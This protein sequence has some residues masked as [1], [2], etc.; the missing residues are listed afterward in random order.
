[1]TQEQIEVL[2]KLRQA[3][4]AGV[5]PTAPAPGGQRPKPST[6]CPVAAMDPCAQAIKDIPGIDPALCRATAETAQSACLA[7]RSDALTPLTVAHCQAGCAAFA[8]EAALGLMIYEAAMA[9]VERANAPP[10]DPARD[11]RIDQLEQ[12]LVLRLEKTEAMLEELQS[13]VA[14]RRIQ[15]YTH[16]ESGAVVLHD[17]PYFDP[18]PPLVFTG[19]MQGRPTTQQAGALAALLANRQKLTEALAALEKAEEEREATAAAA[20]IGASDAHAAWRGKAR[21]FWGKGI[22][23]QDPDGCPNSE[24]LI[25]KRQQCMALCVAQGDPDAVRSGATP[26]EVCRRTAGLLGLVTKVPLKPWVSPP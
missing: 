23:A 9:A 17:G 7:Y 10:P 4:E 20:P 2:E 13:A 22:G 21:D 3:M 24:A 25:A 18:K 1:M 19:S 8:A 14:S 16:S 12:D 11:D 15:V 26:M 5:L 6:Q